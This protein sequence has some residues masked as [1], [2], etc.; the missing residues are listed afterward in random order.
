MIRSPAGAAPFPEEKASL[1][2]GSRTSVS[3]TSGGISFSYAG[4]AFFL[5]FG[6][7]L[8]RRDVGRYFRPVRRFFLSKRAAAAS[9]D[10]ASSRTFRPLCSRGHFSPL[11]LGQ[12]YSRLTSQLCECGLFFLRPESRFDALNPSSPPF[13]TT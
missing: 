3:E 4:E 6:E 12:I 5:F 1:F 11:V 2:S 9:E 10:P 8:V 13:F 7:A